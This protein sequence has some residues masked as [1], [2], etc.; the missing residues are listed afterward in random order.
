MVKLF[1]TFEASIQSATLPQAKTLLTNQP[2]GLVGV[3]TT[4]RTKRRVPK[5]RDPLP[6]KPFSALNPV[7]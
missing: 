6:I 2:M 5:L 4:E 3:C 1:F 7:R